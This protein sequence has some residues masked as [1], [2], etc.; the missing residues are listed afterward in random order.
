MR[1]PI[2]GVN[3][4][5]VYKIIVCAIVI[6]VGFSFTVFVFK[7]K[8]FTEEVAIRDLREIILKLGAEVGTQDLQGY[9]IMEILVTY[10]GLIL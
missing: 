8:Q 6:A 10:H 9:M 7:Q 4:M 1:T 3:N 5:K 2:K